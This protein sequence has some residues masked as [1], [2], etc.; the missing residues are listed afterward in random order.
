MFFSRIKVLIRKRALLICATT[1]M[2]IACES[3]HADDA[4]HA[5][6][7][8]ENVCEAMG[9]NPDLDDLVGKIPMPIEKGR[10]TRA[11]LASEKKPSASDQKSLRALFFAEAMCATAIANAIGEP[12]D[13]TTKLPA[14]D[15]EKFNDIDQ[16]AQGKMTFG[17]FN[18]NEK[19]R[20]AT[21]AAAAAKAAEEAP[22]ATAKQQP[23][24]VTLNCSL[25]S[26]TNGAKYH[27][28]LPVVIDYQESTANGFRA[29][30]SNNEISW[31]RPQAPQNTVWR[32][33]RLSGFMT[34]G[35]ESSPA[36]FG[37]YCVESKPKF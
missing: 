2:C 37:G 24:T 11:M 33:N 1:M 3:A 9:I 8:A 31:F 30:V 27:R 17:A 29:T 14:E 5:H 18:R 34:M 36:L 26:Q 4:S 13:P 25:D 21:L 22:A 28:D 23:T 10:I 15:A 20:R 35:N 16:L 32:L 12:L 19:V 7:A 6:A